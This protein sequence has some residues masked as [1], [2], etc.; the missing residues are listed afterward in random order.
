MRFKPFCVVV[1]FLAGASSGCVSPPSRGP[2]APE[3]RVGAFRFWERVPDT[4]PG[5]TLEGEL[6]VEPDTILVET[7]HGLCHYDQVRSRGTTVVYNCAGVILR[8]D[9]DNPIDRATYWLVTT[10]NVPVRTCVRYTTT[11][12][13][14]R[15]C[16]QTRTV[17]EPREVQRSG[18]LRPRRVQ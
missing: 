1:I 16:T 14:R 11:A 2:A 18:R 10:A 7:T 9:R 15:V 13:G 5:V 12:N 6:V 4:A 8:F 17:M 3:N